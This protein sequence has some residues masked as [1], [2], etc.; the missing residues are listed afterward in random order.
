MLSQ[1]HLT[2]KVGIILRQPLVSY[3]MLIPGHPEWDMEKGKLIITAIKTPGIKMTHIQ[4][5]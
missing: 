3:S 1:W 5:L 2:G 4:R